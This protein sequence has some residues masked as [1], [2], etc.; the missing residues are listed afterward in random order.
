MQ[1]LSRELLNLVEAMRVETSGIHRA[2]LAEVQGQSSRSVLDF[3]AALE[4]HKDMTMKLRASIKV[5]TSIY[6]Q[7]HLQYLLL[8]SH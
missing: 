4:T 8:S 2:Q 1:S 6:N 5:T 3:K 7:V